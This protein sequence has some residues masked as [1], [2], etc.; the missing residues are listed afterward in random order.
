MT[1]PPARAIAAV[2][3][4]V[5]AWP[6]VAGAGTP[7][8]EPA[9]LSYFVAQARSASPSLRAADAQAR[10]AAERIG[11][12]RGYPDPKLLYGYY[13]TP[14]P[15]RGRQEF[16]LMQEVPFFGK[17][18]L[19]GD[20]AASAA[21][22]SAH[23][24]DAVALDIE[25]AVKM[26]FYDYVRLQEI[27]RVL[28]DETLLLERMRSAIQA[29]YAAE[30][31]QQQDVLKVTLAISQLDDQTTLNRREL[32]TVRARMNELI[33]RDAAEPLPP[34]RWDIPAA[35]TVLALAVADTALAYR[36]EMAAARAEIQMAERARRLAGRD[37]FPDF[38][39]GVMFEF[40]GNE[41][42]DN[43]WEL[44]AGINLP[45]WIGKRRAAVRE[46]EAMQRGAEHRFDAEALRVRREVQEAVERVRAA[47]ERRVRF[48]TVILPQAQQTFE[49]SEAG[50]RA[51]R[52][53]FL[54]YLDSERTLLSIR[55]EYYEVIADLGIQLAALERA[56]A[57]NAVPRAE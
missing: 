26:T 3:L 1:R 31:A 29:R 35:D 23:A 49:S 57:L 4:F 42:A 25:A 38:M 36:P 32:A 46:A 2:V 50:Y 45:I 18:G 52:V 20:V 21:A 51:A 54:D 34:P 19:R 24:A 44:M 7:S 48:E 13:V 5:F 43:M 8:I 30:R 53:D 11:V 10:A 17:R 37:Y 33:G 9:P 39:L 12:A 55:R 16:I 27:D 47:E 28:Q 41:G 6:T 22:A 56:L 15:M 14:D 40:G